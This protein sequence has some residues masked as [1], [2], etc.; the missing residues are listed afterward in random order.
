MSGS[1][2]EEMFVGLGAKRVRSLF[3]AAK[4]A[5]PCIVFID[6]L[7]AV[8][9]KR[10]LMDGNQHRQTINQL[11]TEMDGFSMSDGVIVIGATNTPD[12]LDKALIRPGRF[13]RI[14]PVPLPDIRG[15]TDILKVHMKDIKIDSSVHA[16]ILARG[17]PGFSGADLKNL[18]NHAAIQASKENCEFVTMKHLEWAKDKIMMGAERK[19]ALISPKNKLITAYHEVIMLTT[20]L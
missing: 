13:D 17:T 15:R 4:L 5:A 8:G 12:I 3:K 14:V 16:E 6:E 9:G 11:L 1:S 19:S 7:D 18:I 10:G 20:Q 2:F